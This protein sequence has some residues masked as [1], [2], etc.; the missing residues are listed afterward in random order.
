MAKKQN[1]VSEVLIGICLKRARKEKP[2]ADRFEYELARRLTKAI[3]ASKLRDKPLLAVELSKLAGIA[4]AA[5]E[6]A[7]SGGGDSC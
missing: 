2:R 7:Y 3:K 1:P 5:A 6:S 4:L